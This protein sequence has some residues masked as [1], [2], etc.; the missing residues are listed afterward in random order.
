M[1]LKTIVQKRSKILC[2]SMNNRNLKLVLRIDL[3][4]KKF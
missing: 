1:A 2:A 3:N 4:Y